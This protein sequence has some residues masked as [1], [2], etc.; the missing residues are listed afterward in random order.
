MNQTDAVSSPTRRKWLR[1]SPQEIKQWL[2][3]QESSK[4]TVA[5]FCERENLDV[6]AFYRWRSERNSA[7]TPSQSSSISDALFQEV[8]LGSDLSAS[9]LAEVALPSGQTW[10][11]STQAQPQWIAQ[12]LNALT[13]SC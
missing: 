9:W 3:A 1:T 11:F 10:R 6:K 2:I 8:S 5:A 7:D 13:K 12:L 4:L